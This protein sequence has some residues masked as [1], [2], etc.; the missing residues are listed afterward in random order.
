MQVAAASGE[1]SPAR[2]SFKQE[3]QDALREVS[4][5]LKDIKEQRLQATFEAKGF[6]TGAWRSN[7]S[8]ELSRIMRQLEEKVCLQNLFWVSVQCRAIKSGIQSLGICV[9]GC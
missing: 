4:L 8:D 3:T 5:Q 9:W 2:G 6:S 7:S 1:A